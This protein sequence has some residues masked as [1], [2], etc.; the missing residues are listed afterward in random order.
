MN[1][2]K[3]LDSTFVNCTPHDIH[4]IKDDGSVVTFK[5]SGIVARCG[6]I[7]HDCFS[8]ADIPVIRTSLGDVYDLPDLKDST[9]Y[10]VSALVKSTSSRLD[11]LSPGDLVIDDK[12]NIVGCKNFG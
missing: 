11:L 9:W 4:L 1:K 2:L 10:L 8:I 3:V 5:Q 12:G 6:T 7:Y